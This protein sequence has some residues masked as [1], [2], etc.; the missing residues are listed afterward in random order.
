MLRADVR[1]AVEKNKFAI[2]SVQTIDQMMALLTGKEAGI[3]DKNNHYPQG[4]INYLV[5]KRIDKLNKLRKTFADNNKLQKR[6]FSRK[7]EQKS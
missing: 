3:K 5:Q 4:T 2:Y 7:N 6:N 1:E